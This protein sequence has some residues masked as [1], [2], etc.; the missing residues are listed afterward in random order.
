MLAAAALKTRRRSLAKKA[1]AIAEK[2]LKADNWPE[3]YDGKHD[4]FVGQKA[5]KKQAWTISGY[6]LAKQL[7]ANPESLRIV[8]FD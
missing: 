3:Y 5:R 7:I 4:R 2:R 1:I 6:L 8:S